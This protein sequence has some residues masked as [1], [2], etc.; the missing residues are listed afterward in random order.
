M[1]ITILTQA[2]LKYTLRE[3][4]HADPW[5]ASRFILF[6]FLVI[7][8]LFDQIFGLSRSALVVHDIVLRINSTKNYAGT[9]GP[10]EQKSAR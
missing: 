9:C 1:Y 3:R 4:V 10:W 6:V 2:R 8:T 5:K 7:A